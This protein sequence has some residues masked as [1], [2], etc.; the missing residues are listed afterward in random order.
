MN[1]GTARMILSVVWVGCLLLMFLFI[2]LQ[3]LLGRYG[4]DWD[5]AWNWAL[6][7]TLPTASL[8]VTVWSVGK[9]AESTQPRTLRGRPLVG[10]GDL[11][12]ISRRGLGRAAG[13]AVFP[14]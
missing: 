7:L 13:Q 4:E 1:V 3:S 12:R 9:K 5:V 14:V 10:F 11:C 2:L 6:P 8:V